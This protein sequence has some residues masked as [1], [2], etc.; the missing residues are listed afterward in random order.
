[1]V[2]RSATRLPS[3]ATHSVP[4]PAVIVRTSVIGPTADAPLGSKPERTRSLKDEAKS[5]NSPR[6]RGLFR[7]LR[8]RPD[9][10]PARMSR[11]TVFARG[12]QRTRTTRPNGSL[13]SPQQY[14]DSVRDDRTVR[15]LPRRKGR[16][17]QPPHPVIKQAVHTRRSTS[18]WP[19]IR[20]T[21]TSAVVKEGGEEYSRYFKLP[22]P[23]T[24]SQAQSADRSSDGRSA[25]PSWCS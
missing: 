3:G 9:S 24:T 11:P 10:R 17:R 21:M 18:R 14:I 2:V 19:R 15:L 4:A 25:R 20:N 23:P 1:M 8:Q 6:A 12:I 13:L 7:V 22:P 16:R 5:R